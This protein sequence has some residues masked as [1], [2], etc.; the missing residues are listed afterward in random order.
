MASKMKAKFDRYW[1]KCS[2]ALAV[3]AILDPRFKMKLVEYYYSQ[4]YGSTAL[5]R[6]KEVSDGI[7]ELFNAYSICS[8]LVDQGSTLPGSSLPSTSTDS[9]DRL[10]G[11]DKFLH[12]SSQGQSAISDL[13]KYLEEPVFPRNCDFNILNWWKVHTPRYP[14]LSMMARDI[15]GTPMSTIAPELAFGVGGRVLDSYRSSLNPDTRQ[16]LICTRDW[17]QVESEG[18]CP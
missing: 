18:L 8:T 10:K 17:L 3:A 11:F 1:S 13:D 15:L 12:E 16:A 2:L 7:K 4:I 9:R 5:D 14:I 6:I